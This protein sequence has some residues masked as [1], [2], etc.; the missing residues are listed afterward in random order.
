MT[1]RHEPDNPFRTAAT[2]PATAA[3]HAARLALAFCREKPGGSVCAEFFLAI[4][5]SPS[6]LPGQSGQQKD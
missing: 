1:A 2:A 6:G 4:S 5:G 3:K